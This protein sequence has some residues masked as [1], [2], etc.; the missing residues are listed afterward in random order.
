MAAEMQ[1]QDEDETVQTFI[2]LL[3]RSGQDIHDVVV[4]L[5]EEDRLRALRAEFEAMPEYASR[6]F[7]KFVSYSQKCPAVLQLW[8]MW[9]P[10]SAFPPASCSDS[11]DDDR[12]V[13]KPRVVTIWIT[14]LSAYKASEVLVTLPDLEPELWELIFTFLKHDQQPRPRCVKCKKAA[15]T[16]AID[17]GGDEMMSQSRKLSRREDMFVSKKKKYRGMMD[18]GYLR[19]Y[20]EEE[21]PK[22][23]GR[24]DK[25]D[26]A[27]TEQLSPIAAHQICKVRREF[28]DWFHGW[29]P[30]TSISRRTSSPYAKGS[31]QR[32]D[33]ELLLQHQQSGTFLTRI[34]DA[35][36]GYTLSLMF[37]GRCKHF[38]IHQNDQ[39]DRYFIAGNDRTFATLNEL[40]AFHMKHPITDDGDVL[41]Q[42]CPVE[43]PRQD[44]ADL[45]EVMQGFVVD[46]FCPACLF[47]KYC[48]P[49]RQSQKTAAQK[50]R[51]A[52]KELNAQKERNRQQRE[53]RE[54]KI[55]RDA[56]RQERQR[57]QYEQEQ[58]SCQLQQG[59]EDAVEDGPSEEVVAA[60][61]RALGALQQEQEQERLSREEVVAAVARARARAA[62]S[63]AAHLSK[64]GGWGW[65]PK[66]VP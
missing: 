15:A 32:I 30:S 57:L 6:H 65:Q 3:E 25:V 42:A 16:V 27:T 7:S 5:C 48:L 40:V 31:G 36:F 46:C 45:L 41:V 49:C 43:G 63:N 47:S 8:Q 19:W 50:E 39:D 55:R 26:A 11:T 9:L 60:V 18:L 52:Q 17:I 44:L 62:L 20:A 66:K 37:N 2:N 23:T 29:I 1:A 4:T 51:N 33:A 13:Y 53:Q 14:M 34:S 24:P 38:M 59:G 54:R 58:F 21:A 28:A 61:D 10:P 22:R 12:V 56:E 35:R 64:G